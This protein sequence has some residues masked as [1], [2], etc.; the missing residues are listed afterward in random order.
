M[1][2]TLQR[3]LARW[4]WRSLRGSALREQ[5]IRAGEIGDRAMH[6]GLSCQAPIPRR[7]VRARG[8]S[9]PESAAKLPIGT[10][11]EYSRSFAVHCLGMRA[12]RRTSAL[13][14]MG[15]I[16]K[17]SLLSLACMLL[18]HQP[19]AFPRAGFAF[20]AALVEVRD[21]ARV[22]VSSVSNGPARRL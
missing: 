4:D 13:G 11:P 6:L 18:R 22:A 15:L 10:D 1:P 12:A 20:G 21:G 8:R 14:Y 19:C 7:I 16:F 3:T 17:T 9:A 2:A 5:A